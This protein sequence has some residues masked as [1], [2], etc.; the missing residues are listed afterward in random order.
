[1]AASEAF[2]WSAGVGTSEI[3][4]QERRPTS[5]S[6]KANAGKCLYLY[7]DESG[8]LDFKDSGSKFFLMTCAVTARPFTTA[9]KLR[10][11]KFD[12]IE[13]GKDVEKLHACKDSDATRTLVYDA[14]SDSVGSYRVYTAY[15]E[16]ASLA[17]R[18]KTPD[19]VYSMVFEMLIDE[20]YRS[21]HLAWVERAIVI[22]DKLPKD[23][24]R[25]QVTKPLK[26]YMKE[27]FQT[28]HIPYSLFHRDSSSD[29]NLQAADY[30]CWAAHREITLG[31]DWPIKKVK[32][33]FKSIGEIKAKEPTGQ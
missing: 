12:L 24:T 14:L 8:N 33:S 19:A 18:E 15:I 3:V 20:I 26:R 31:K 11:I 9:D 30:F 32:G 22:T 29:M 25:R 21:E 17:E 5:E 13:S 23:A 6:W 4:T 1:M 16:K 28:R 27:K 2:E 10:D 7:L